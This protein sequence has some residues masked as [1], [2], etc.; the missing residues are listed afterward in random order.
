MPNSYP[1]G[2]E[3]PPGLA[4]SVLDELT[5][6]GLRVGTSTLERANHSRDWWPRLIPLVAEGRVESWPAC[7]IYAT[8]TDD[9]RATLDVARRH[10]LGV[11][12]QGGRSSVV[13]GATPP[14]GG[15][16]LDLRGMNRL[17]DVDETSGTVSVQVGILGT[18]L[19][20][21]LAPYDLSVG[22]F[23]QSFEL[24][25]V[26]GWIASRGAGQMSNRYGTIDEMVRSLT[27]VL[28]DA[29]VVHVGA[30]GPREAVG[31]D[32]S[33]LFL[34][35]EGALGVITEAILVARRRA[36]YD[37]R[38]AYSFSTFDDGLDACRRVVQRGA[39][40]AVLR[41]YDATESRRHFDVDGNALIVLDEGDPTLVAATIALI[42]QE[43]HDALACDGALVAHWL[44]RR[45]DVSALAP[46]WE[47]GVV[48]DTIEVAGSWSNLPE[49]RRRVCSALGDV[50][51]ISMVSVHQS[52]AYL[53]GACLYFTFA[54]QAADTQALYRR[55]WDVA[56]S[57]VLD[58]GAA[59]SHHH[60]V[61]RNR[62]RFVPRTL[63]D[64]APLLEGIKCLLDPVG[65]LN[66][67]VL[68]LAGDAW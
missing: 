18:A 15:I 11:T 13:G 42:D 49:L 59:I 62:A 45:N 61:G 24:A 2:L 30:H 12:A 51:G 63:G 50:A 20:E 25:S 64:A 26:G 68:G 57:T 33:R 39:R 21:E 35:S 65:V 1:A 34:G 9:V 6:A 37:E 54:G 4:P 47:R 36:H 29:T 22:H 66:P 14:N 56:M 40:P 46:L 10:R 60:G 41:L 3:S 58:A 55:A 38:R 52:H 43:C 5:D 31:P 17:L 16:A 53:D 8:S 67:G 7:V 44:E 27:V 32:L 19:E 48:V 28:A 23:P